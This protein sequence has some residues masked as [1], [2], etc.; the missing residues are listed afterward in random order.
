[1]ETE[2]SITA[3]IRPD[4]TKPMLQD[5]IDEAN[6]INLKALITNDNPFSE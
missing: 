6:K 1:M 3:L 4:N 5:I 2:Y